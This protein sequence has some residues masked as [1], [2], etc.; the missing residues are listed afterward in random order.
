M[1]GRDLMIYILQNGLEN[2]PV[3]SNGSILGF[4][5]VSE[6]AMKF[7]VG[8][9]TVEVWYGLGMIDGITLGN[10]LFI[11]ANAKRPSEGDSHVKKND[12]SANSIRI[13]TGDCDSRG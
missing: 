2:E 9:A 5:T 8:V 1:T 3:C 11:P 10:T 6:A 12:T 7:D 4:M 13:Y